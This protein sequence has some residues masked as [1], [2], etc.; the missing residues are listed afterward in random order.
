MSSYGYTSIAGVPF[1][2]EML[3]RIGFRKSTYPSLRY[4]RWLA[5]NWNKVYEKILLNTRTTITLAS[6][7]CMVKQKRLQGCLTCLGK[8]FG[9]KLAQ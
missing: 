5:E 8:A 2:Y 9:K 3:D 7:L 6:L 4:L 1:V